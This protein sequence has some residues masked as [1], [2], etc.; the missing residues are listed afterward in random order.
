MG[1]APGSIHWACS[2]SC[3]NKPPKVP[4]SVSAS[5]PHCRIHSLSDANDLGKG[6]AIQSGHILQSIVIKR[7]PTLPENFNEFWNQGNIVYI[8]FTFP[9]ILCRCRHKSQFNFVVALLKLSHPPSTHCMYR[10]GDG[11]SQVLRPHFRGGW[12]DMTL[13]GWD[14]EKKGGAEENPAISRRL[15]SF[16]PSLKCCIVHTLHRLSF[17]C[18][19]RY[20]N[21]V[22]YKASHV[23]HL[24]KCL[25]L[26]PTIIS[27]MDRMEI[28]N[29]SCMPVI[30]NLGLIRWL[31]GEFGGNRG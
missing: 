3:Q 11:S 30:R 23:I 24:F 9:Y 12:G 27:A 2:S 4:A 18:A 31:E 5:K 10:C 6:I 17:Q 28:K 16:D 15:S 13:V 7:D 8:V 26:F 20:C 1:R 19:L 25:I 14:L 22:P 21:P 29:W